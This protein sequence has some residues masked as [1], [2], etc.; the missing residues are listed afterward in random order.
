MVNALKV[1]VS[2]FCFA[3]V[4]VWKGEEADFEIISILSEMLQYAS[5]P[6]VAFIIVMTVGDTLGCIVAA[7]EV[8]PHLT[9]W[10]EKSEFARKLLTLLN[11]FTP[12]DIRTATFGVFIHSCC[13]VLHGRVIDVICYVSVLCPV[14]WMTG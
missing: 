9:S 1:K 5:Y 8:K 2:S 11:A 6:A 10:K 4:I 13:W 12:P 7:A 3:I 14:S